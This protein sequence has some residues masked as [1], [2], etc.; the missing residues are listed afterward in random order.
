MPGSDDQRRCPLRPNIQRVRE[1][2]LQAIT[3]DAHGVAVLLLTA[4]ALVLF[5][6]DQIP[7][8][9][10][11]LIVLILLVTG[12]QLFPYQHG[13]ASLGAADLR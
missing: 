11:S 4:A 9:T 1:G 7:L 8:E 10:S 12:F 6:R 3:P 5:T 2:S 13:D